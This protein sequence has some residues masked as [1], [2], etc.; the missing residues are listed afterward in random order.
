M[1]NFHNIDDK[2]NEWNKVNRIVITEDTP[3][4]RLKVNKIKDPVKLQG[5]VIKFGSGSVAS[6]YPVV[7]FNRNN[8][9]Y[10]SYEDLIKVFIVGKDKSEQYDIKDIGKVKL[11]I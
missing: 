2:S 1:S 3:V 11:T 10:F 8:V 9:K 4:K 5:A 7:Y 6:E